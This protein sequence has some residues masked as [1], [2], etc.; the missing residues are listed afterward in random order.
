[1]VLPERIYDDPELLDL[2]AT[3]GKKKAL[4]VVTQFNHPRS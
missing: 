3:Y 1:M 2:F 4:Y